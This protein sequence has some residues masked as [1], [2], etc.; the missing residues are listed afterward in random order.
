M[1]LATINGETHTLREWA[2]IA[3][4]PPT[5]VYSRYRNGIRGE[6]LITPIRLTNVRLTKKEVHEIWKGGNFVWT[7]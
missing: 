7:K 1:K 6:D 2:E 3:G 4:L 5:T